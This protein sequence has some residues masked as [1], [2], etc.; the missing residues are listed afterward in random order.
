MPHPWNIVFFVLVNH[1]VSYTSSSTRLS[2]SVK[3]K[4]QKVMSPRAGFGSALST[5]SKEA[6]AG[7]ELAWA[8]KRRLS[9]RLR[10]NC[11]GLHATSVIQKEKGEK[12]PFSVL[13][14]SVLLLNVIEMSFFV[15]AWHYMAQLSSRARDGALSQPQQPC[16]EA[17]KWCEGL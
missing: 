13:A 1:S 6:V 16:W 8:E 9:E 15:S 10:M 11:G 17:G 7:A 4:D 12:T 14:V 5:K 2:C 3:N